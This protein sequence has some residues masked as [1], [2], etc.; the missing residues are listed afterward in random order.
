MAKQNDDRPACYRPRPADD[1]GFYLLMP[2]DKHLL[3]PLPEGK[4]APVIVEWEPDEAAKAA[5]SPS[6]E[7]IE[8]MAE[9]GRQPG[10]VGYDEEGRLVRRLPN[11]GLEVIPE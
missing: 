6:P 11:G 9:I 7:E 8:R 4:P 3:P 5:M 10:A 1:G 2:D